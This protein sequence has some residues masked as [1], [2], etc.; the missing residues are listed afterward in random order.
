MWKLDCRRVVTHFE[1]LEQA[2]QRAVHDGHE[3]RAWNHDPVQ[4]VITDHNGVVI[5]EIKKETRSGRD[6]REGSEACGREVPGYSS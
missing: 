2:V 4:F 1:R 6:I 5:G 3:V